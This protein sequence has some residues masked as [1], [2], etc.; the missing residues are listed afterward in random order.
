MVVPSFG[1]LSEQGSCCLLG[2]RHTTNFIAH[3][4]HII[5]LYIAIIHMQRTYTCA[6]TVHMHLRS[7]CTCTSNAVYYPNFGIVTF[8]S[9]YLYIVQYMYC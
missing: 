7:Q 4:V 2:S 8:S 3:T 1:A 5:S 9:S 6:L